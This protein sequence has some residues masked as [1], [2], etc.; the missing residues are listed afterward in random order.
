MAKKQ[1]TLSIP[2]PCTEDWNAMTPDKNGK[3]CASCQKTVVDFS[4]MT[5]AEIFNYFDTLKGSTCG[6]FTEKQLTTPFDTPLIAKPQNRWAWALSA[7]LLP[8]LAAS[9][10]AKMR[11]ATEIVAPSVF[12]EKIV[13]NGLP[14][15]GEVAELGTHL[16]LENIYVSIVVNGQSLANTVTDAKGL[17]KIYLPQKF[18]NQEFTI[19]FDSNYRA[20]Q[21]L[22]FPNYAAVS[23]SELFVAME[24]AVRLRGVV[25]DE[26][27]EVLVGASIVWQGT[28]V[29]TLTDM[30]GRFDLQF[31][32]TKTN[33]QAIEIAVNYLGYGGENLIVKPSEFGKELRITLKEVFLGEYVVVR[34]NFFQRTKYRIKRFFYKLRNR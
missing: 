13:E 25:M 32:P 29:G 17:F 21:V 27:N 2:T 10:T 23:N 15:K 3:F 31:S 5:D 4:R 11:E 6:R 33:S 12:K 34:L 28:T 16:P 30:D 8:T 19:Y 14:I 18:D 22:T 20:K 1:L 9:Q 24:K 26:N 7:L